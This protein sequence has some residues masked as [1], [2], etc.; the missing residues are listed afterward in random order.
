MAWGESFIP[1]ASVHIEA[2]NSMASEMI[3]IM[4]VMQYMNEEQVLTLNLIYVNYSL[5]KV[6]I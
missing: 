1:A 5:L 6:F 4:W 3:F 2:N